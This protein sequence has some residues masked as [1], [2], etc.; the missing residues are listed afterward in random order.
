MPRKAN[1]PNATSAKNAMQRIKRELADYNRNVADHQMYHIEMVAD[2]LLDLRGHIYGPS[3]SPFAGG[4]FRLEIKIPGTYP[5]HPP[6]MKFTTRLWHPNVCK[7][8]AF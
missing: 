1:T 5:F 8:C 7:C 4:I 2:N 3:D 6:K